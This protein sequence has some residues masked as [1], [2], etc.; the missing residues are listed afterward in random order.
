MKKILIINP[1]S[2]I[3]L[4]VDWFEYLILK[5]VFKQRR[6]HFF[7]FEESIQGYKYDVVFTD[8]VVTFK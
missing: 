5:R 7:R 6:F 8:E 2:K 1:E 3:E 4:D